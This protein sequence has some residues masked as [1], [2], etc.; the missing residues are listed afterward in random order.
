MASWV[1]PQTG[2]QL[3]EDMQKEGRLLLKNATLEDVEMKK[4]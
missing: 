4:N 1:S 2:C 3:K